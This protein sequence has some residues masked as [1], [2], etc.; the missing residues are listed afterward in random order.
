MLNPVA[1][2]PMARLQDGRYLLFLQNHDGY[3]YGGRGPLDLNSRRPQFLAVGEFREGAQQPVWFSEPL[4]FCDTQN[5]GVFPFYM[6]W[7][8]MYASLTEREEDRV[9]ARRLIAESRPVAQELELR[10]ILLAIA[11]LDAAAGA[12]SLTGREIDVLKNIATGLSNNNIADTLH[13]SH[14]TV[15]THVRN[16]FRKISVANRTEAADFARRSDLLDHE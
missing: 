8:S 7:L 5:V 1:P 16:I 14:S 4:L 12:S 13:I 6:K 2:T 3:G 15:A 9:R 11:D 10:P